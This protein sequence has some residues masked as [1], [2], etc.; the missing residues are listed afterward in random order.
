MIK[1]RSAQPYHNMSTCRYRALDA[2]MVMNKTIVTGN[3]RF[4]FFV[5]ELSLGIFRLI[6]S[7]MANMERSQHYLSLGLVWVII[8]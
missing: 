3:F 5:W 7:A 1:T 8:E 4:G 6:Y 2:A